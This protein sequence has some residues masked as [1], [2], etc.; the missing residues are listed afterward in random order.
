MYNWKAKMNDKRNCTK[1]NNNNNNTNDNNNTTNNNNNKAK[2]KKKKTKKTLVNCLKTGTFPVL[3]NQK[4][5]VNRLL[6]LC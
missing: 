3:S 4:N 6:V 2:K 5:P 1:N